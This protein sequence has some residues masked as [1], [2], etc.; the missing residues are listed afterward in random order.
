MIYGSIQKGLDGQFYLVFNNAYDRE[1]FD[2][3]FPGLKITCFGGY[4]NAFMLKSKFK[5]LEEFYNA[6]GRGA[7]DDDMERVNCEHAGCFG[8]QQC[9]WCE[10]CNKPRFLCNHL[11]GEQHG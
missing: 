10:E 8:H 3:V 7:Q 6:V 11:A 2:E 1:R 5:T 9:G 4:D